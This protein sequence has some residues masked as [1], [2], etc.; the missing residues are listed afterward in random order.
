MIRQFITEEILISI[1]IYFLIL[2]YVNARVFSKKTNKK[3]CDN[4]K[5][6]SCLKHLP[7]YSDYYNETLLINKVKGGI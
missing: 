2:Y 7:T 5:Y 4:K 1:Q 3:V 6:Q